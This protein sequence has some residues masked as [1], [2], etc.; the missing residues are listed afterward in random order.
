M[1][2]NLIAQYTRTE[3]AESKE[4]VR[5]YVDYVYKQ[6]YQMSRYSARSKEQTQLLTTS[7][8]Q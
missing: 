7:T 3:R 6:I 8:L 1:L 4:I 2:I 5:K